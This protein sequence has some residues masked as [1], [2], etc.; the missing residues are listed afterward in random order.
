MSEP[1]YAEAYG[2]ADAVARLAL[3]E[4]EDG[5]LSP[6]RIEAFRA[7]LEEAREKAAP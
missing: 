2:I 7:L 3:I 5:R 6:E 4:A 1:N